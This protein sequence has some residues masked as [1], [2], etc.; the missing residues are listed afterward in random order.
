MDKEVHTQIQLLEKRISIIENRLDG[1]TT[2]SL[3]D[4]G[5]KKPSKQNSI[6]HISP[7]DIETFDELWKQFNPCA[8]KIKAV[9]IVILFLFQEKNINKIAVQII[10]QVLKKTG[11]ETSIYQ[12]LPT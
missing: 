7:G 6:L 4:D 1:L 2:S 10:K 11:H 12:N 3:N 9:F 8:S 5:L